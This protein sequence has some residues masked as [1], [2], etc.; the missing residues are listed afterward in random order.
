MTV[1]P[2]DVAYAYSQLGIDPGSSLERIGEVLANAAGPKARIQH[3]R[4][5]AEFFFARALLGSF[6]TSFADIRKA[7]HRKAMDLH[8]DRNR[9]DKET[10]E[11]LK[12]INAAYARV[13]E[14]NREAKAYYKQ[15]EPVCHDI[16]QQARQATESEKPQQPDKPKEKKTAPRSS[17]ARK[18]MAAS[19]P[20][21]IRTARL[22]YLPVQ[23]IIGHRTIK[24]EKDINFIFD[25]VMLPEIQ[26]V[27]AKSYLSAPDIINAQLQYGKFT[28]AYT[29]QDVKTVTVPPG[30]PDPEAYA[31]NY[32]M[33]EFGLSTAS[34][35][36]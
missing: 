20:R 36:E 28:P 33:K 34:R 30:E 26:F 11:Q 5:F 21:S 4:R 25:I 6:E 18:Y 15:P 35:K 27:R 1:Y 10:E 19:I 3:V 8:P 14:I 23:T 7:Y 24:K 29:P 12:A 17:S 9:G 16:E 32:F 31:R 22:G 13:E 2:I